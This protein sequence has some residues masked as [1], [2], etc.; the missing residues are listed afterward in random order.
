MAKVRASRAKKKG[1]AL[2]LIP[3][4]AY[5]GQTAGPIKGAK[6]AAARRKV[7]STKLGAT[8]SGRNQ[9]RATK[10][11]FRASQRRTG[12]NFGAGNAGG[13]GD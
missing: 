12:L 3:G 10:R 11:A 9:A 13:S 8:R 7:N 5:G 1:G 2:A 6:L 4:R